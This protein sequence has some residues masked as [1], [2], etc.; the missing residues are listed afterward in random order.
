MEKVQYTKQDFYYHLPEEQIAQTPASPRDASRLLVYHR[1]NKSIENKIFRDITE[2]L[3]QS[4]FTEIESCLFLSSYR[5]LLLP[6]QELHLCRMQR[7]HHAL[8]L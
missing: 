5:Q 6:L 3:N 2:Y 1:D 4:P 7:I 8:Q